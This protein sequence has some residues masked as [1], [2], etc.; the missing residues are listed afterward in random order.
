MTLRPMLGSEESR[1]RVAQMAIK[2][3]RSGRKRPCPA[4]VFHQ[5]VSRE[6]FLSSGEQNTNRSPIPSSRPLRLCLG[7]APQR[8]P[9]SFFSALIPFPRPARGSSHTFR[10]PVPLRQGSRIPVPPSCAGRGARGIGQHVTQLAVP[11][12]PLVILLELTVQQ[13]KTFQLTAIPAI[14]PLNSSRTTVRG[15]ERGKVESMGNGEI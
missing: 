12:S 15:G 9:G 1:I 10:S 6:T 5:N 13:G 4:G 11:P 8:D 14:H 2:F 7:Q 3:L